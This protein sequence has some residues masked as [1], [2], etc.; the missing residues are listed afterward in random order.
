M[1]AS[2]AAGLAAALML[3]ACAPEPE[4]PRVATVTVVGGPSIN[5][6]P[7]GV[8]TPV[9]VQ[10]YELR[11]PADFQQA[12]FFDLFDA[13]QGTLGPDLVQSERVTVRPGSRVE[14]QWTLDPMTSAVGAVAAFREL[15]LAT[16]RGVAPAG[17]AKAQAVTVTVSGTTVSVGAE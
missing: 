4:P 8:A 7:E 13:A 11:Q 12:G 2:V 14:R 17:P 6:N 9:V 15:D 10:L 5:P 3:G 1:R 16:W